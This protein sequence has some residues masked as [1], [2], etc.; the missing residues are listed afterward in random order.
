MQTSQDEQTHDILDLLIANEE[1]QAE[2]DAMK[3]DTD[4]MSEELNDLRGKLLIRDEEVDE[5]KEQLSVAEEDRDTAISR[6]A[7][8]EEA[9][10]SISN[11]TSELV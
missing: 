7:T 9:L 8:L 3:D 1:L 6:V 11:I 10:S 5:L 2:R 4:A